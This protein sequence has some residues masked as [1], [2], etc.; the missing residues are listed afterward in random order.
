MSLVEQAQ[1]KMD[2]EASTKSANRMMSGQFTLT[3]MLVQFQQL[4]NGSWRKDEVR[5]RG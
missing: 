4:E 1:D 5:F 2:I 3:D